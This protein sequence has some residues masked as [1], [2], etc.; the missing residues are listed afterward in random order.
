MKLAWIEHLAVVIF[1][2]LSLILAAALIASWAEHEGTRAELDKTKSE[3][4]K[5]QNELDQ[6]EAVLEQTQEELRKKNEEISGL[7][8]SVQ[9]KIAEIENLQKELNESEEDL[10]KTRGILSEA[11][12]EIAD[13]RDETEELGDEIEQS[14]QWFTDNSELPDIFKT[15]RLLGIIERRCEES[16]NL[17]LACISYLM[18]DELGITYKTDIG[19]DQLYSIQ[20]IIDR[21]G[22][23]CED[24]SL[25]FK[26][27]IQ[28]LKTNDFEL[29][30][31]ASGGG[32]Y[33]I[34][35]DDDTVWY[36][37]DAHAVE[38]GNLRSLNAYPVCYYY[39]YNATYLLGHCV[40]MFTEKTISS[41]DDLTTE[42]LM[43]ANFVE[44]QN[45]RYVGKMGA[46]FTMCSEGNCEEEYAI[47]F[48]ITENDL[49]EFSAGEWE[50][51]HGQKERVE[52]LVGELDSIA[53]E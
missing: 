53:L 8:S 50:Y 31:W 45:G 14:I 51:Y 27:T 48:V 9:N 5:A 12:D 13:I 7:N 42:N 49:Y 24:F 44:P 35:Q 18:E 36:Y 29:E 34:Y 20:E 23:D 41:P 16:G 1:I 19:E 52:E 39:G 2:V 3:L 43:D 30:A 28:S 26:A 6:S 46:P 4:Q 21:K 17:R 22:G 10:E 38:I 37:E 25:F 33:D 11:R 40:V 15:E 47:S 32:R